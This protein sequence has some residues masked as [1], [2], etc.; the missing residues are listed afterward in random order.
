MHGKSISKD[1]EIQIS[2]I[3]LVD[4][5]G[6]NSL[7]KNWSGQLSKNIRFFVENLETS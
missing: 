4:Q 1:I 5:Y 2:I 3:G 6:N 7:Q